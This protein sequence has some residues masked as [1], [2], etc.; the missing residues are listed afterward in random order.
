M[1]KGR[2][3]IMIMSAMQSMAHAQGTSDIMVV[4]DDQ[5]R[6]ITL[7]EAKTRSYEITTPY[8]IDHWST[9]ERRPKQVHNNQ[10]KQIEPQK[11]AY[12]R[13]ISKNS[14]K[15]NRS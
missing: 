7:N 8:P 11:K 2:D 6:G 12:K 1:I 15:I 9:P 14:R 5:P 10:K 4:E 3:S 13:R